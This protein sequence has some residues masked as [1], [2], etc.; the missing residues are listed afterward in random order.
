MNGEPRSL[1]KPLIP[2][3][4]ESFPAPGFWL[5]CCPAHV[6]TCSRSP[7]I[8]SSRFFPLTH[9]LSSPYKIRN[10]NFGAPPLPQQDL[11]SNCELRH[12]PSRYKLPMVNPVRCASMAGGSPLSMPLPACTS[13]PPRGVVPNRLAQFMIPWFFSEGSHDSQ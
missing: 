12:R 9:G 3:A 13:A 2:R 11:P 10:S 5:A 1:A 4:R 7:C 8:V 6:H